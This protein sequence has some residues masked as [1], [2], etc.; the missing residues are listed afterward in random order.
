M[1]QAT[2]VADRHPVETLWTEISEETGILIVDRDAR[3]LSL[4]CIMPQDHLAPVFDAAALGE[5]LIEAKKAQFDILREQLPEEMKD[6]EIEVVRKDVF[7]TPEDE[8]YLKPIA[9]EMPDGTRTEFQAIISDNPKNGN[10]NVMLPVT[11]ELPEGTE[12]LTLDP[13]KF[14]RPVQLFGRDELITDDFVANK[15]SVP[16]RPYLEERQATEQ[17]DLTL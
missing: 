5:E 9:Y 12:I 3:K 16:M 8:Q 13:E 4:L 6:W 14:M 7:I 2:G 15:S 10:L 17:P 11:V 1:A